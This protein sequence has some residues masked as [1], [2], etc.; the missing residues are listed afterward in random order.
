[1]L[2]VTIMFGGGG[3]FLNA[4]CTFRPGSPS[5]LQSLHFDPLQCL[6]RGNSL[7]S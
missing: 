3:F 4:V 1:M 2:S 7:I 6:G 5:M